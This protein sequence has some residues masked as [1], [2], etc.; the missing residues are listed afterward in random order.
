MRLSTV[1]RVFLAMCCLFVGCKQ[2]VAQCAG[3]WL[4]GDGLL[5]TN[6]TVN[7]AM[8]WD[9][10][11]SGPKSPQLVIAG[12]FSIAGN[13]FARNIAAWDPAT[14]A[15]ST[16][17]SG[18]GGATSSSVYAL[19]ALP[20]GDLGVFGRFADAG[21]TSASCV[22]RWNGASWSSIGNGVGGVTSPY[23]EAVAKLPNGDLVIG[24]S[25][26]TAGAVS[27]TCLARWDG[28]T[29]HPLGSGVLGG[30]PSAVFA[31]ATMPN[32]DVIAGGRFTSAG[33]TPAKN[34]ARWNGSEWSAL[35]AGLDGNAPSRY[36]NV[37]KVMPNGILIAGG[38]FSTAGG[39]YATG[40]AS[41]DGTSWSSMGGGL[42]GALGVPSV[43]A[44]ECLPDGSLIAGGGFIADFYG[45]RGYC[46]ARWD[47][48]KWLPYGSG[49]DHPISE[50]TTAV[51]AI[52]FLPNNQMIA[53][54][55]FAGAGGLNVSN[56]ALWDGAVWKNFGEGLGGPVF[57]L[58]TSPNGNVLAG[59]TFI[60]A[61][62]RKS[63]HAAL[64]DGRAWN[65]LGKGPYGISIG[66]IASA[67]A[68][69]H[70][71]RPV[72]AGSFTYI[73]GMPSDVIARW[74]SESWI[75]LG[76][77]LNGG[78]GELVRLPNGDLIA[79]GDFYEYKGVGFNN[80]A[81]WDG[82]NWK[83]YGS[84]PGYQSS[85]VTA[86]AVIQNGDLITGGSIPFFNNIRRWNGA[87]WVGLGT[88]TNG[89]VNAVT[90]M[91]NG[92]L[93]VG[94][95]FTSAGGGTVNRIAR[96]DGLAWYPLAGGANAEVRALATLPDGDLVAGGTFTTVG[97]I[98]AKSIARW[99]GSSWSS[100]G[101]GTNGDVYALA[102]MPNGDLAVG[103]SF[104]TVGNLVSAYW[105]RWSENPAPSIALQPAGQFVGK[106]S[107]FTLI[108]APANGFNAVTYQWFRNQTPISD[109]PGGA[110]IGGGVV[111]GAS[112]ALPS[113]TYSS[114]VT[115][116]IS[117][118]QPSDTGSYTIIFTNPCGA[119]S[120]QPAGVVVEGCTGDLNGDNLVD[121]VD[122]QFFVFAY[123]ILDC[124]DP[125]MPS[126]CAADLN[127]DGVVDDA[128]FSIFVLAY[129]QAVCS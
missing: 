53:G 127:D 90:V 44:I 111:S 20:N 125:A 105:A 34:I 9:P 110:S 17:N 72:V 65:G 30:A 6:G 21:G 121:S 95:V 7:A 54:G 126:T 78:I 77:S 26:L 31:L 101:G 120:S 86:I 85:W 112:G 11:G 18:V 122:F 57:A 28:S 1:S 66:P 115:L 94:G 22:A 12:T 36:P 41:W 59:G 118:V 51:N 82:A 46:I 114:L 99:N 119:T 61:G 25:F 129:D 93:A 71:N 27:A 75:P 113:P 38:T 55:S 62:K 88:G 4:P 80:I 39:M 128:D 29:W 97:N 104:T 67:V 70:E 64:W 79:G 107:M 5:G 24:G 52:A 92:D 73:P 3:Q 81:S 45:D 47:G 56:L 43:N 116:A 60:T 32:G 123:N 15:W 108:A 109:G 84:G 76:S 103:G 19:C 106:H 69:D 14:Q 91:K 102:T 42:S 37:L 23:V 2:A 124:A 13:V 87:K 100:L 83:P 58:A 63:D 10:D 68:F 98:N 16:L 33:G 117:D 35:G 96:W 40:I 50:S 48:V 89:T 74:D 49:I 8:M